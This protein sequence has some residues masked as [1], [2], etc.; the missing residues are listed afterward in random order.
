M[1][2]QELGPEF[3]DKL[4]KDHIIRSYKKRLEAIGLVVEISGAPVAA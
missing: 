3:F 4:N 2:Y 1:P